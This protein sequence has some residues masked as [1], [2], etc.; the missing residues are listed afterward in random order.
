[1]SGKVWRAVYA[2]TS[3]SA[4]R[5]NKPPRQLSHSFASTGRRLVMRLAHSPQRLKGRRLVY[6][7]RNLHSRLSPARESPPLP[8]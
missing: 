6:S 3:N 4:S 1:M 5:A 2:P 8:S 7:K